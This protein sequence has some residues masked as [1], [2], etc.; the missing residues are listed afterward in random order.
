[1]KILFQK[2][3][4]DLLGQIK[5]AE[6]SANEAHK[7]LSKKNSEILGKE[8]Q[9]ENLQKNFDSKCKTLL[10]TESELVN[11]REQR[12]KVEEDLKELKKKY[13]KQNS[14]KGGY[15]TH[16]NNLTNEL[17][18][19][20]VQLSEKDRIIENLRTEIKKIIPKKSVIDY[21]KGIRR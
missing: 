5:R 21:E 13:R 11:V 10:M 4:D 1:M 3:Y 19:V 18:Q 8:I 14:Q 7:K 6:S 16:I 20:K 15:V 2:D 17:E 12:D 9:I